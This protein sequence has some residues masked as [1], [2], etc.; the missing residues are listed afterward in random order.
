MF[1]PPLSQAYHM[2]G[3][4][5]CNVGSKDKLGPFSLH[6]ASKSSFMVPTK[7]G[8]ARFPTLLVVN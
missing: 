5:K 6:D 8:H 1:G 2:I 3:T 4:K 7:T